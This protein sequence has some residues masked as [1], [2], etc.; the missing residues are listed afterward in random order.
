MKQ[1]GAS[2]DVLSEVEVVALKEGNEMRTGAVIAA[3]GMSAR[4]VQFK[5]LMKIGNRTMAERVIM[6]FRQAGV[7]E[8]AMVVGYRSEQMEKELRGFGVTFLKNTAYET[9]EMFESVKIGFRYFQNRCEK[10]LFCPVDIPFFAGNTVTALLEQPG[11]VVHPVYNGRS[12]HPILIRTSCIPEILKFHG[13]GGL[14]AA[15]NAVGSLTHTWVP[16]EDEA[17]LMDADTREDLQRLV[18]LHNAS[19]MHPLA[20]VKLV[21]QKPFFEQETLTLLHQ[22]DLLGSVREACEKTGVSYS[23]G[24]N[25]IHDAEDGVGYR[26]VERQPGGKNGGVA[27][28]TAQGKRLMQLFELYQNRVRQ[29]AERIFEDIFLT[30]E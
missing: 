27:F 10:V 28:V 24:W 21:N 8:I 3:A 18:D 20:E 7:E 29:E 14:K 30:S 9:T 1:L 17:V 19:M 4:M 12:G 22:I 15:I 11:D 26:I 13:E 23:K 2:P 25:I 16:V 6:N 5:Q